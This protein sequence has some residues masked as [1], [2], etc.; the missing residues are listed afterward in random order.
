MKWISRIIGIV[1]IIYAIYT[2]DFREIHGMLISSI[3]FLV[4]INGL[5]MD[6]E[7]E[8]LRKIGKYSSRIAL[9]LTIFLLIKVFIIG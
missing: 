4:G 5:F 3:L 9:A 6:C 8:N 1:C 7:Q 2:A